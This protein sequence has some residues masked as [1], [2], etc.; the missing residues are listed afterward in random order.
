MKA[1]IVKGKNGKIPYYATSGSA[2]MDISAAEAHIL[3]PGQT[4]LVK[5]DLSIELPIG[6]EAQVRTRSGM[7]L[8]KGLI[9]LNSPGTIDSDYRGEIGV[10][11]YNTSGHTQ[12]IEVGDR[13]AQLV[14]AKYENITWEEVYRLSDSERGDGG[15]GSTGK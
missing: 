8:K 3:L 6:L 4:V 7:A 13:I 2:G 15:F 11:L 9:V 1:K 14:I 5:T 10:I 12:E